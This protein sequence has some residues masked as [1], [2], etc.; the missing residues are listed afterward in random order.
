MTRIYQVASTHW[1]EVRPRAPR[2]ARAVLVTSNS[3]LARAA[4]EYGKEFE[5][6]ARGVERCRGLQL[7][8]PR[9]LKAPLAAP[10]LPRLE[11]MAACYAALEPP[12]PCGRSTSRRLT[13]FSARDI[14]A[15][16]MKSSAIR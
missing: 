8:E 5:S 7:G 15:R 1:R 10:D 9:M 11:I 2:D 6:T 12:D 3:A 14:S 16:I 13:G 4:F